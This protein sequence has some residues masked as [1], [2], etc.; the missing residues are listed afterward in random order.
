MALLSRRLFLTTSWYDCVPIMELS[1]STLHC[2]PGLSMVISLTRFHSV[3]PMTDP[4]SLQVIF[5][6][7]TRTRQI[8]RH[9]QATVSLEGDMV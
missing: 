4:F 2:E 3:E 7:V 9:Y 5:T 6:F 1:Y 8:S